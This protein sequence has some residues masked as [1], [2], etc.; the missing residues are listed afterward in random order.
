MS[1]S[2]S[3]PDVIPQGEVMI[4]LECAGIGPPLVIRVRRLLKSAL[5]AYGLRAVKVELPAETNRE[6]KS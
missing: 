6:G 5:R 2:P 3:K 4:C 1:T